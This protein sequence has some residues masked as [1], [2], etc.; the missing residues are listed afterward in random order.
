MVLFLINPNF[1]HPNYKLQFIFTFLHFNMIIRYIY[2]GSIILCYWIL[3]S[4]A[5]DFSWTNAVQT[6]TVPLGASFVYVEVTGAAGGSYGAIAG[7]LG[8]RIAGVISATPGATWNIY[9]GGK[10]GTIGGTQGFN[11]GG[12]TSNNAGACPG[13][14]LPI[15]ELGEVL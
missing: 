6:W 8:A 12:D 14:E 13:G 11:G 3:Q 9:V 15:S 1:S 2:F 7:G 4:T 5:V 10:G